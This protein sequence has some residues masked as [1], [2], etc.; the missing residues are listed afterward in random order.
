MAIREGTLDSVSC[1]SVSC[2]KKRATRNPNVG[3]NAGGGEVTLDTDTDAELVE[4]VVGRD[5]KIRWETLKE[6]RRAE[7]GECT[8]AQ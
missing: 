2:T 1:P 4:S 3:A 6:K 5:L 7:L 8:A